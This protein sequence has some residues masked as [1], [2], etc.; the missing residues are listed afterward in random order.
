MQLGRMM[1]M[2]SNAQVGLRSLRFLN[3]TSGYKECRFDKMKRNAR[4]QQVHQTVAQLASELRHGGSPLYSRSDGSG[5]GEADQ[6]APAPEEAD[7][8]TPVKQ[9]GGDR[10]WR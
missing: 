5:N 4:H 10:R 6:S 8:A 2:Q 1:L 9:L 7:R 3:K